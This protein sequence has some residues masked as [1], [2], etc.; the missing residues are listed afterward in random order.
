MRTV[1]RSILRVLFASCLLALPV[2]AAPPASALSCA[3]S[4]S[5][6]GKDSE[7]PA[8][9]VFRG[10]IVDAVAGELVV[11]VSE[12]WSGGPVDE[13]VRLQVELPG[14]TSWTDKNGDIPDGYT[15][16]RDWLFAST[17]VDGIPQVGP[18]SAWPVDE[19][20]EDVLRFRPEQVTR[21][22]PVEVAAPARQNAERDG[23]SILPVAVGVG[24]ALV[25]VPALTVLVLR[26]RSRL[27]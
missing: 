24:G 6:L 9:S 26:R 13:K 4:A 22:R 7:Y 21:P 3:Y 10:R 27:T 18:C 20:G 8:D 15:D 5:I 2:V 11:E 1:L 16:D 14:W 12:V 25:V 17:T 23:N 19:R